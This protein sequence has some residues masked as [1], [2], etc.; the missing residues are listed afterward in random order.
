MP[1]KVKNWY[2]SLSKDLKRETKLDK[3]YKKHYIQPNSTICCI[4]GTGCGKTTSLVEFL[5]RKNKSF[6]DI[7]IF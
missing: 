3:N 1:D 6:Y 2:E 4:E 7:I 5:S